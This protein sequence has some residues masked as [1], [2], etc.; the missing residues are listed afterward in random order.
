MDSKSSFGRAILLHLLKGVLQSTWC[1]KR[2]VKMN[3][4]ASQFRHLLP[5][6]E[7]NEIL[8][9]GLLTSVLVRNVFG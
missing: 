9:V 2:S 8:F 3:Y 7:N 4:V 1:V 5:M 6:V